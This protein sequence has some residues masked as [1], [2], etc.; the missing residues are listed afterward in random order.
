[1]VLLTNWS[2]DMVVAVSLVLRLL[3]VLLQMLLRAD[4]IATIQYFCSELT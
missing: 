1:M 4:Q 3:S 2:V